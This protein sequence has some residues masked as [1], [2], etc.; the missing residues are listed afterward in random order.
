MQHFIS[1]VARM[2]KSIDQEEKTNKQLKTLQFYTRFVYPYDILL[3]DYIV[4]LHLICIYIMCV[5]ACLCVKYERNK[6]RGQH[7]NH[8][9]YTKFKPITLNPTQNVI[10]HTVESTTNRLKYA[11]YTVQCIK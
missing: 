10:Q 2:F 7:P 1:E 5:C 6:S 4:V 9:L 11:L 8:E 3:A